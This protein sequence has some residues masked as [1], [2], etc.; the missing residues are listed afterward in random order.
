MI[1]NDHSRFKDIIKGRAKESLK[2]YIQ[3]GE[4]PAKVG[5][6]DGKEIK[7]PIERIDLP[8]FKFNSQ[9]QQEK[10]AGQSGDGD[11][12]N[13]EP[14]DGEGQGDGEAG[15]GEGQKEIE[16]AFSPDEVAKILGEELELPNIKP[17]GKKK[18]KQI[19]TKFKSLAPVGSKSLLNY[20]ATFKE[21]LK[22]QISNNE[23]NE[24]SPYVVP[25]KRD[26]R[27]RSP[28]YEDIFDNSAVVI[29]MMDVSGSMGQEQ[30]EIVRTESFWINTWL[31]HQ[32][33]D[34]DIRYIIHDTTAKEVTEDAFFSTR[35]SGGTTISSAY[36][37]A[38]NII[39]EEYLNTNIYV[40]QFSDGDNWKESDNDK[41][42]KMIEDFFI[43]VTNLFCY[44]QVK[45]YGGSG[46]YYKRLADKFTEKHNHVILSKIDNKEGILPSIKKFLGKGK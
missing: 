46:T 3:K 22:R 44:G 16:A 36:D 28:T 18:I 13:G 11:P 14:Q 38:K 6:Q 23:Y 42:K 8:K 1:E 39:L 2:K 24:D 15:E 20:K 32:Y 31:K 34:I 33:K 19:I 4:R 7:V 5:G 37:L 43:P 40:F 26:Y 21:A 30:K 10:G 41:C 17:K 35:E 29:Y 27:F 25:I 12:Q 9:Q 45:S